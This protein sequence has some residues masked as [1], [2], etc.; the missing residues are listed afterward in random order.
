MRIAS[1]NVNSIRARSELVVDW[2]TRNDI[3]VLAMQET[4]CDSGEF[5]SMSFALAG[6]DVV[7]VG[8]GGRNGVALASRT[9]LSDIETSF[10]GQPTFPADGGGVEARA[11]SARCGDVR[12]WSLYVPNGRAIDDPHYTYKLN[13]LTALRDIS[14][15]WQVHDP[16]A[17]IMLAGDWNVAPTDDDVWDT[18]FFAGKT[19][20]TAAERN[21]VREFTDT[22]FIDSAAPFA[23]NAYTFWDYTQLRFPRN[24]GMRIDYALCSP[25]LDDRITGAW[26]DRDAR[27]LK[28]ASDHAPVVFEIG[29][30]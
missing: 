7:N 8:S 27:K 15:L 22:G 23:G 19:H 16:A 11:V 3:D 30:G 24:E 1:W 21:A 26:V 25:A 17:Q 18:E 5:P 10:P 2:L 29:I 20:V 12:V 6:Y 4:K 28:G 13:W 14:A 9:V